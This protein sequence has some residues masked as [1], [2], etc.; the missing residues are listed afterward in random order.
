MKR[1]A[2]EDDKLSPVDYPRRPRSK[3][4]SRHTT[5]ESE[6]DRGTEQGSDDTPL[7][8]AGPSMASGPGYP[9]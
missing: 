1:R 4:K 5:E 3:P 9:P 6:E 2:K 8:V 7:P